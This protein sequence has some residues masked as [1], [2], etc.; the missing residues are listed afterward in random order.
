[1]NERDY[2]RGNHQAWLSMLGEC[3]RQ[4]GHDAPDAARLVKERHEAIAALRSACEAHGDNDWPDD[5]ALADIIEKH[6][7][8]HLPDPMLP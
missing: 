8:R 4:L 6:L 7:A 5:L 3:L 2:V 1:M